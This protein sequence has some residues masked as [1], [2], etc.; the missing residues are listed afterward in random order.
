MQFSIVFLNHARPSL[1]KMIS[2]SWIPGSSGPKIMGIQYSVGRKSIFSFLP[3]AQFSPDSLLVTCN[4]DD[5]ILNIF[6]TLHQGTL[7]WKCAWI[8]RF[9][10]LGKICWR[11]TLLAGC[12]LAVAVKCSSGCFFLVWLTFSAFHV[13]NNTN[14]IILCFL[15][16]RQ[17]IAILRKKC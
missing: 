11:I 3:F 16:D 17:S 4:A 5:E 13:S 12:Q 15:H 6:K 14:V 9:S 7:S 8:C 1:K 10:I 2:V